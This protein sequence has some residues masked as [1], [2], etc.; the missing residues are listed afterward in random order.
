VLREWIERLS[1]RF[2]AH[3]YEGY[4]IALAP[5]DVAFSLAAKRSR[6]GF[7]AW[8]RY[9][10]KTDSLFDSP[11]SRQHLLEGEVRVAAHRLAEN[12]ESSIRGFVGKPELEI[13]QAFVDELFEK[14]KSRLVDRSSD[15]VWDSEGRR[16]EFYARTGRLRILLSP[17]DR[18]LPDPVRRFL[19]DPRV[20]AV[21]E[22]QL[23]TG[24]L[25]VG[26]PYAAAEVLLPA[27][28]PEDWHIDDV[29]PT[30]KAFLLLNEVGQAQG[31]LRTIPATHLRS[32]E[33]D[34]IYYRICRGGSAAA[35][36]EP[37]QNHVLD[38]RGVMHTGSAGDAIFFDTRVLHAGSRCSD[39]TRRVL[40]TGV[41]PGRARRLNPR[42]FRDPA[43][44]Q[45]YW[46]RTAAR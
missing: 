43:P 23:G 22:S 24:A 10:E 13:A 27:D 7:E 46:Q 25:R 6:R 29:R 38:R 12:G 35:Y 15:Q 39:G 44:A 4:R 41:R 3:V 1:S 31:P 45:L 42:Y 32:P 21:A 28:H 5:S 9:A 36:F 40:I 2:D 18:Q 26:T 30:V 16:H 14:S 11:P 17:E 33:R 20:L 34:E 37:D 8:L 19:S